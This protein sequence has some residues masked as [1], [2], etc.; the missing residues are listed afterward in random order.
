[1]SKKSDLTVDFDLL[2]SSA[3]QLDEIRKEFDGLDE[4]QEDVKVVVGDARVQKAVGD[5]VDN[6]DRNRK[7]LVKEIEE[8]GKMVEETRDA[9][10]G[11]DE[12]L[13]QAANGKKR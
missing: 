8:V 9:F 11:L 4:W 7:R 6:W 2:T 12:D 3:K 5:F 1:M 13:A 10:Q